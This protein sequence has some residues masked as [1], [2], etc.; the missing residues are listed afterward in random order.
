MLLRK[1]THSLCQLLIFLVDF[2]DD[3]GVVLCDF[4]GHGFQLIS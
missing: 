1:F 3:S 2:V 4:I